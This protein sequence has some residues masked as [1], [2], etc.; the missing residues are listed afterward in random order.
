MIVHFD[1]M[2]QDFDGLMSDIIDFTDSK[3]T[4]ELK[5]DIKKTADSQRSFQSKH[6]Y[7]L[8]K[9]GLTEQ[10]IKNDCHFIYETFLNTNGVLQRRKRRRV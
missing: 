3:M 7:D 8:E 6:K 4:D 10:K 2:M 1:R 9:F 5:A